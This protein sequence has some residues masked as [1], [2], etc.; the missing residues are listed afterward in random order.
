MQRQRL[1]ASASRSSVVAGVRVLAQERLHRHQEAGRAEPALERVRLVEGALERVKP[2][3][4]REAL[5]RRERAA[6]RL[7]REH[8]ARAHRLAVELDGAG[9]THALLAADLRAGQAGLVADEVGQERA[10]LDLAFVG[11]AR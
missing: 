8:Q 10:R 6:V 11:A 3:S 2:P 4:P 7:D 9:A 1:P 5:D